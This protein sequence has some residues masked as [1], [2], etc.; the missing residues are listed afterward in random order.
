MALIYAKS[1]EILPVVKDLNAFEQIFHK[2]LRD[3][4]LS[5][6]YKYIKYI[7]CIL[8]LEDDGFNISISEILN[9]SFN[10]FSEMISPVPITT[11]LFGLTYSVSTQFHNLEII[12]TVLLFKFEQF[13]LFL[14]YGGVFID[15]GNFANALDF[16][17]IKIHNIM[18]DC[19]MHMPV[20]LLPDHINDP[21]CILNN[22]C[23]LLDCT[24]TYLVDIKR[25][26]L[27]DILR[28][29][30]IYSRLVFYNIAIVLD[31]F[32]KLAQ[33]HKELDRILGLVIDDYSQQIGDYLA[34]NIKI[35][36]LIN[37]T[38]FLIPYLFFNVKSIN[39]IISYIKKQDHRILLYKIPLILKLFFQ[40]IQ[41]GILKKLTTEDEYMEDLQ[42]FI[43]LGIYEDD[44]FLRRVILCNIRHLELK[45]VVM[46]GLN[47]MIF[48]DNQF[49]STNLLSII[50]E[51]VKNVENMYI[52]EYVFKRF[53]KSKEFLFE[54]IL[55]NMA[56]I[57][58]DHL[59]N[60]DFFIKIMSKFIYY[61]FELS[62]F[63]YF[64]DQCFEL[65]TTINIF[66]NIINNN[67]IMNSIRNIH[68]DIFK[69]SQKNIYS[70]IAKKWNNSNKIMIHGVCTLLKNILN[71]II[72]INAL[73]IQEKT[74]YSEDEI[75][76]LFDND[77]NIKKNKK[78]KKKGCKN[79]DIENTAIENTAIENTAIENT[80]I[81][82]TAIENTA[83]ENTDIENTDIENTAIE[84]T[85]IENTDIEN[86]VI[87]TP[88]IKNKK[89]VRFDTT[90]E[91]S[92]IKNSTIENSTIEN[93]DTAKKHCEDKL[94]ALQAKKVSKTLN[95]LIDVASIKSLLSKLITSSLINIDKKD[96]KFIIY[97]GGSVGLGTNMPFDSTI[98]SDLDLC[99]I[100][101]FIEDNLNAFLNVLLFK[102]NPFFKEGYK[103]IP[104]GKKSP[105]MITMMTNN[106]QS[107]PIDLSIC[108]CNYDTAFDF[109]DEISMAHS[110]HQAYNTNSNPEYRLLFYDTNTT[111]LSSLYAS[112]SLI[113][114][115]T[116]QSKLS[117]N[118]LELFRAIVI[119]IKT[120]LIKNGAYGSI[121]G[122]LGGSAL[123]VMAMIII[124]RY[125]STINSTDSSIR[126]QFG[127]KTFCKFYSNIKFWETFGLSILDG[128]IDK[129]KASQNILMYIDAYGS[130]LSYNVWKN[131]MCRTISIFDHIASSDCSS[132]I[133]MGGYY[134]TFT[135][136]FCS[137]NLSN[138]LK[139][140]IIT[141][142]SEF[143]NECV[144]IPMSH[145]SGFVL[146]IEHDLNIDYVKAVVRGCNVDFNTAIKQYL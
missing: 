64:L 77:T 143:T 67:T 74:I 126:I 18:K 131:T 81:E 35:D 103:L 13:K 110:I 92:T 140:I 100:I 7:E 117:K 84:N 12:D 71:K 30:H 146:V 57:M 141:L 113:F 48:P 20:L 112:Y 66:Y 4:V 58:I 106:T 87:E 63:S 119:G 40:C 90:I 2:L 120:I 29:I 5:V 83:I 45:M 116:I 46:D 89:T 6:D 85:A 50:I 49:K 39:L 15:D 123:A 59:N 52:L 44:H 122:Y 73:T 134:Y 11:T 105:T 21:S 136:T 8:E 61:G 137:K 130:C 9:A 79:T 145:N 109:T 10:V 22:F 132:D 42:L 26:S 16:I 118:D 142:Q 135:G 14:D 133:L 111:S 108:M 68:F 33:L 19:G 62:R 55:E 78:K 23:K 72:E 27:Y 99:L 88:S 101:D 38:K 54:L 124:L 104:S 128:I 37:F 94:L 97:T 32:I 43:Q 41:D 28:H 17:S 98:S 60:T 31:K 36:N 53:E 75:I 144:I 114:N 95:K 47:S 51:S 125:N 127:I 70:K 96:I 34:Q 86:T 1:S 129:P 138:T 121:I 65:S 69:Y 93:T 76:S 3:S 56:K 139:E 24:I 91:N 82:N 25:Y 115:Y 107:I 102:L 80:A